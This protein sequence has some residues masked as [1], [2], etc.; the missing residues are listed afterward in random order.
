MRPRRSVRNEKDHRL[1]EEAKSCTE[2][3]SDV[4]SNLYKLLYPICSSLDWSDLV[5]SHFLF[6]SK[7]KKRL[8]VKEL[9][10]VS[11]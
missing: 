7:D 4:T 8:R 6:V 10:A 11:H 1:P 3:S 9:A 2:I 5:M